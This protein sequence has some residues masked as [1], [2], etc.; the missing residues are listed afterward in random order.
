M[1]KIKFASELITNFFSEVER[2]NID[3][4]VLRNYEELPESNSSK[5]VDILIDEHNIEFANSILLHVASQLKYHL[6]WENKL[7]YLSG[8]AFG[9]QTNN[10]I[11]TIKIDLFCGLKWR[12][13]NYI[14]T[15][16]IFNTKEKYHSLYVPNKSHEAF[17]MILYYIL[18]A[19]N[20]K[21]KYFDNIYS[22]QNDI[23]NFKKISNSTLGEEL[24][25][26]I[27]FKIESQQIKQLIA[28]RNEIVI[29]TID[30]NIMKLS[31]MI[32]SII[33]HVYYEFFKRNCFGTIVLFEKDCDETEFIN[34]MFM[35]L[36][37]G[38]HIE[39]PKKLSIFTLLKILRSNPLV[40]INKN[41]LSSFQKKI[42]SKNIIN[43]SCKLENIFEILNN[44][45]EGAK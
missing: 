23:E 19:K 6:I 29:K 45:L 20:I 40:V 18:Y 13:L 42:F 5:D 1:Y 27:L 38:C 32:K 43:I 41:N 3:Y 4:V 14:D 9:R 2:N 35:D 11:E 34:N 12:G 21:S 22:C 15:N 33:T 44:K 36:G 17:I 25:N 31:S 30:K 24:T 16:I 37:I 7:D 39:N 26:K 28:N 10:T 8:Y